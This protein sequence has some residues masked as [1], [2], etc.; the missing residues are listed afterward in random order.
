[1]LT[2]TPIKVSGV[3]GTVVVDMA[4]IGRLDQAVTFEAM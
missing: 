3:T 4:P 1:M 2:L